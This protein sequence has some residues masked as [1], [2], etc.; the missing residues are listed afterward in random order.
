MLILRVG[1]SLFFYL[2]FFCLFRPI[3]FFFFFKPK[4]NS[5]M[6]LSVGRELWQEQSKSGIISLSWLAFSAIL[7]CVSSAVNHDLS[8]AAWLKDLQRAAVQSRLLKQTAEAVRRFHA[9]FV[10]IYSKLNLGFLIGACVFGFE[11]VQR[12]C[13]ED[14]ESCLHLM[15]PILLCGLRVVNLSLY[16]LLEYTA[17]LNVQMT[18]FNPALNKFCLYRLF[19]RYQ[20]SYSSIFATRQM[21]GDVLFLFFL[22]S[23]V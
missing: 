10:F 15:S 17:N 2:F 11:H 8:S 16:R 3:P 6:H 14:W 20:I 12:M 4:R 23:N 5:H 9:R 22:L 19:C 1:G 21:F 13:I 7:P 18:S